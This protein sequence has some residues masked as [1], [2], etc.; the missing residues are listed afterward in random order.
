MTNYKGVFKQIDL[1][2]IDHY[3]IKK[4]K[5][6]FIIN[7]NNIFHIEFVE[8]EILNMF[9][10]KIYFSV[11][12]ATWIEFKKEE[13]L[14]IN[15]NKYSLTCSDREKYQYIKINTKLNNIKNKKINIFVRKF[16]GLMV[17]ARSDGFGARLMPILNAMYL[18]EYTGFKFGFVWK[19][20]DRDTI[21]SDG[22]QHQEVAKT[23]LLGESDIF[24]SDFIKQYSYTDKL[25]VCI[26]TKTSV[27]IEDWMNELSCV[28]GEYVNYD[29]AR[30]IFGT[31]PIR[32]YPKLWKKIKFSDYIQKAIDKANN[33][34][35]INFPNKF[36]AIHIRSGDIVYDERV[37]LQGK[38]WL[39]AM[40]LEIA[41]EL[42][43]ENL[44][45]NEKIVLF[46]DDFTSLR[47]LKNQYNINI[48]EDYID[49]QFTNIQRMIFEIVFMSNA[50]DIFSGHSS[51]SRVASYIGLGREPSFYYKYYSRYKMYNIVK[52]KIQCHMMHSLQKS[53]SYYFLFRL[54]Y[55]LERKQTELFQWI[56]NAWNCNQ[57]ND[58]YR[59]GLVLLGVLCNKHQQVEKILSQ[60]FISDNFWNNYYKKSFF[61]EIFLEKINVQKNN[62]NTF[63]N[64][65][66]VIKKMV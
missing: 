34:V 57:N 58:L 28:W 4:D 50:K 2:K 62:Q 40:P 33:I 7:L 59:I 36:I 48:I 60:K 29:T 30:R 6:S 22:N 61:R 20:N 63:P 56:F 19:R 23:H 26:R 24:S 3:D 51:F 14:L 18:A 66:N 47:E 64:I 32:H 43:E 10:I 15:A 41:I 11:D 35:K 8:F 49:E 46:G 42:I 16:P 65:C 38:E 17:A 53:F 45:K 52:Q 25:G 21:L 39:K 1:K 44:N 55:A 37:Y 9:D 5:E 31:K 54:G 12:K 27:A 13:C